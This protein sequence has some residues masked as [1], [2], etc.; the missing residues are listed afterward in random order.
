MR[1]KAVA[2]AVPVPVGVDVVA[3]AAL[4]VRRRRW[5]LAEDIDRDC[6]ERHGERTGSRASHMRPGAGRRKGRAIAEVRRDMRPGDGSTPKAEVFEA[7]I[8]TGSRS[9]AC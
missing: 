5:A 6:T 9:A 7:H 1:T 8:D 4:A 3:V 2:A